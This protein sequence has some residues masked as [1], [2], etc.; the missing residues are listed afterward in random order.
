MSNVIYTGAPLRT[1]VEG[2]VNYYHHSLKIGDNAYYLG[3]G[4]VGFAIG[5]R[6]WRFN[7][8]LTRNVMAPDFVEVMNVYFYQNSVTQSTSGVIATGG[9]S[10]FE[11]QNLLEEN[12]D[13]WKDAFDGRTPVYAE[14]DFGRQVTLDEIK[15]KTTSNTD[16]GVD[17]IMIAIEG[18]NDPD[19]VWKMH[20]F[21][22]YVGG[23]TEDR[24]TIVGDLFLDEQVFF[25]TIPP[26]TGGYTI[27]E[28]KERG[29][30]SVVTVSDDEGLLTW[31]QSNLAPSILTIEDGLLTII[32]STE[33]WYRPIACINLIHEKITTRDCKVSVDSHFVMSYPGTGNVWYNLVETRDESFELLNMDLKPNSSL[34]Y[35]QLESSSGGNSFRFLGGGQSADFN[36]RTNTSDPISVELWCKFT[37]VLDEGFLFGFYDYGVHISDGNIGFTTTNLDIVSGNYDLYGFDTTGKGMTGSYIHLVFIVGVTSGTYIYNKIYLNGTEQELSQIFGSESPSSINFNDGLGRL[38]YTTNTRSGIQSLNF[39]CHVF[40]IYDA[41]LTDDEITLNYAAFQSRF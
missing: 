23:V 10:G 32:N 11:A 20:R 1:T 9:L 2:E 27:Y 33:T 41:Q 28:Y 31:I 36:I 25:N 5:Y 38:A 30:P 15:W 40:R 29:G 39:S 26:P 19:G 35:P 21:N 34:I 17:P 18:S 3:V 22:D 13:V 16:T 37:D 12:T 24:S 4:N 6:Y 7:V 8:Y 14:F